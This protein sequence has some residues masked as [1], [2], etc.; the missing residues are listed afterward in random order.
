MRRGKTS[1]LP[2]ENFVA[3]PHQQTALNDVRDRLIGH[4]RGCGDRRLWDRSDPSA[5]SWRWP[6]M[7]HSCCAERRNM[8]RLAEELRP[9]PASGDMGATFG[10]AR[11][12]QVAL[13]SGQSSQHREHEPPMRGGG[14]CPCVGRA[15]PLSAICDQTHLS[16]QRATH[17]SKGAALMRGPGIE[18]RP[19]RNRHSL[20][21]IARPGCGFA[22]LS[23]SF[24]GDRHR[25]TAEA[26][27]LA[28]IAG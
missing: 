11:A 4:L 22:P 16:H 8:R 24:R 17:S 20:Q 28:Y 18:A 12:H 2:N 19:E 9:L 23:L 6:L 15:T 13:E 27:S 3:D 1:K 14:V 26:A 10:R 7:A 21:P 25:R 5:K